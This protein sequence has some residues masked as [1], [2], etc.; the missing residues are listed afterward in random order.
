MAIQRY[1]PNSLLQRF[2]SEIDQMFGRGWSSQGEFPSLSSE[3]WVPDV[4]VE[5]TEDT[6]HISADVPGMKPE[7]INVTFENGVLTLQGERKSE[8]STDDHRARRVERHYGAFVR[9]FSLPDAANADDIDARVEH[10]V[11]RLTIKKKAES[12]PRKIEVQG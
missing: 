5:E 6:Y 2:Q 3:Q 7:D 8:H 1:D 12:K 9:R 4:D 10:G 11:L